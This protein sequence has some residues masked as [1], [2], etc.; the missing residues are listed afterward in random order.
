MY[1]VLFF[2][3]SPCLLLLTANASPIRTTTVYEALQITPSPLV[4]ESHPVNFLS[5][6]SELCHD[7]VQSAGCEPP[8]ARHS[9]KNKAEQQ[10]KHRLAMSSMLC[11]DNVHSLGCE[12]PSMLTKRSEPAKP[13][14]LGTEHCVIKAGVWVCHH[15]DPEWP[16]IWRYPTK[17]ISRRA[18]DLQSPT[19][20]PTETASIE[21]PHDL[22]Y[23]SNWIAVLSL[24]NKLGGIPIPTSTPTETASVKHPHDLAYSSNWI[25]VLSLLNKLG[26]IPTP[27]PTPTE[28]SIENPHNLTRPINWSAVESFV[29]NLKA[30]MTRTAISTETASIEHPLNLT[31]PINWSAIESLVSKFEAKMNT[32]ATSIK[33][34]IEHPLNLTRPINW[35]AIESLV[36]KLEAKMTRTATSTET[37]SIEHPQEPSWPNILALPT[38][39][40]PKVE[41]KSA[42]TSTP[43][44]T[45]SNEARRILGLVALDKAFDAAV[46]AA[47]T[48]HTLSPRDNEDELRVCHKDRGCQIRPN[49]FPPSAHTL[50]Y[51]NDEA[52]PAATQTSSPMQTL[53]PTTTTTACHFLDSE[54]PN[55]DYH[56]CDPTEHECFWDYAATKEEPSPTPTPAMKVCPEDGLPCVRDPT[57]PKYHPVPPV[58]PPP[59][60]QHE[61]GVHTSPE[62]LCGANGQECRKDW[63]F[64]P[65]KTRD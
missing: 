2:V 52:A 18:E 13:T 59:P 7:N 29:S 4:K 43:T 10:S 45:L 60:A 23:S 39:N 37:S 32:T 44:E 40:V 33:S 58:H 3:A 41:D 54:C 12:P 25:A 63:H 28:S 62:K 57:I 19:Q 30:K 56:T 24:L 14:S 15:L 64:P 51:K 8:P 49:T 36:S 34:S 16:R 17:T 22:A 47:A 61:K 55:P 53:T 9:Q 20:A 11:A 27:T 42:S 65:T 48:P 6:S 26:A 5:L 1:S 46:A 21:L 31:R 38:Q 35:S 50:S